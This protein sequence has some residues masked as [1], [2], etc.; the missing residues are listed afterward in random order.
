[1][2]IEITDKSGR[3]R[4]I[5]TDYV[6]GAVEDRNDPEY[7]RLLINDII[8]DITISKG[9]MQKVLA[10]QNGTEQLSAN[11]RRLVDAVQRL[12]VQVPHTI[13]LHM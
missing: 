9:Q 4:I 2:L 11:I 7:L 5:N 13:R 10:L 3:A 1:M 6:I 8:D 12:T